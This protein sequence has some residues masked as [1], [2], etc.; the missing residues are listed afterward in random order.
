MCLTVCQMSEIGIKPRFP[1]PISLRI[2]SFGTTNI[3]LESPCSREEHEGVMFFAGFIAP[4]AF[5][6]A[7]LSSVAPE[8]KNRERKKCLSM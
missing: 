1:M 7:E 6:A 2:G 3:V 4:V 8:R 5:K